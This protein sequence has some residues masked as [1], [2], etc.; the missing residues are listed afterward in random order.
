MLFLAGCEVSYQNGKARLYRYADFD[1]WMTVSYKTAGG[2]DTKTPI[3]VFV[4][5]IPTRVGAYIVE[6][7]GTM[8]KVVSTSADSISKEMAFGAGDIFV[9]FSDGKSIE[10]TIIEVK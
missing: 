2:T 9:T 10:R 1:V 5:F 3:K 7:G 4:K 6:A 8:E